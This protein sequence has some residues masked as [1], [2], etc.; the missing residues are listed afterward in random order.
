MKYKWWWKESGNHNE[1][2]RLN[3]NKPSSSSFIFIHQPLRTTTDWFNN[4]QLKILE[5]ETETQGCERETERVCWMWIFTF[6]LLS[7]LFSFYW[8]LSLSSHLSRSHSLY[9]LTSFL[10]NSIL[11]SLSPPLYLSRSTLVYSR[12]CFFLLSFWN[13]Q[14]ISFSFCF[15]LFAFCS[16]TLDS[17][18][19]L[20]LLLQDRYC[21]H[22]ILFFFFFFISSMWIFWELCNSFV[23][24]CV[25][26]YGIL[27]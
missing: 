24:W 2:H 15:L 6:D 5:R 16:F 7:S 9:T 4:T 1:N 21:I 14:L 20:L 18:W 11:H 8:I 10:P 19:S 22:F 26:M 12:F 27:V 23:F 3:N 13:V 25:Y 17:W